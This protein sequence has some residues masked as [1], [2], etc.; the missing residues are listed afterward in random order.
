MSSA[1][2][3]CGQPSSC[4]IRAA[5]ARLTTNL[6]YRLPHKISAGDRVPG[7]H[8]STFASIGGSDSYLVLQ[9]GPPPKPIAVERRA[10][11]EASDSAASSDAESS[12]EL[13]I[14]KSVIFSV[15]VH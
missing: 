7:G 3:L 4:Q 9:R 11:A 1:G 15:L 6:F 8:S 12:I 14:D 5:I 13:D 10:P 2:A